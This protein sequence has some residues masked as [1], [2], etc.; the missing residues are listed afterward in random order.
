MLMV[1]LKVRSFTFQRTV[2]IWLVVWLESTEKIW[3]TLS[4]KK[5]YR[6]IVNLDTGSI[7][8]VM[9][10]SDKQWDYLESLRLKHSKQPETHTRLKNRPTVFS[11]SKAIDE[12]YGEN[13]A[14]GYKSSFETVK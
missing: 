5:E 6:E 4:S 1:R 11:A 8:K 7:R 13:L 12:Y 10:A 3:L 2:K 14:H 9:L